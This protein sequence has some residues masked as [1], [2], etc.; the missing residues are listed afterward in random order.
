MILKTITV[1]ILNKCI[2]FM[3]NLLLSHIYSIYSSL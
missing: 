2:T 1:D 3:H